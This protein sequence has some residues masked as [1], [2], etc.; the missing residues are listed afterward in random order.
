MNCPKCGKELEPG[1][2]Y[3]VR[4]DCGPFWLPEGAKLR[5]HIITNKNTFKKE[6]GFFLEKDPLAV[7]LREGHRI[8][9]CIC[10][11]CQTGI[12]EFEI[13]EDEEA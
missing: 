11:D 1:Y 9:A 3:E 5:T 13:P 7:K 12:F 4:K 2:I 6:G 8:P 10:R